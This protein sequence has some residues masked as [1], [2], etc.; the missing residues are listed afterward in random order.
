MGLRIPKRTAYKISCLLTLVVSACLSLISCSDSSISEPEASNQTHPAANSTITSFPTPSLTKVATATLTT[1]LKH[2]PIPETRAMGTVKKIDK[3]P[4]LGEVQETTGPIGLEDIQ[5][6]PEALDLED[7]Q[8]IAGTLD[9]EDIQEIAGTLD[10]EDIQEIAEALDLED[11]PE[12]TEDLDLEALLENL[13]SKDCATLTD[14]IQRIGCDI[15]QHIDLGEGQ[16]KGDTCDLEPDPIE[17]EMCRRAHSPPREDLMGMDDSIKSGL[18]FAPELPIDPANPP[19]VATHNFIDLEPFIRIT[20][21]RSAYGHNYNYGSPEYDPTGVSCSS[22]KHYF[23]A[24]NSDQRWSGNFGS[25]DTRGVVKF[26]SPVDG[27]LYQVITNEIEQGTEYQFYISPTNYQKLVFTF[28]HVDLLEEFVD[29]GSVTAGQHLGYIIRPNGQGEI[30]VAISGDKT[31]YISFFDVMTDEVFAEY[32]GRGIMNRAQMT[33]PKQ[34]RVANPIP[35]TLNDGKGGKFYS[36]SGNQE[37]FNVWQDGP[38]NWIEL[39]E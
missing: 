35:C 13:E 3:S 8:E 24:Y 37:D 22:M 1:K 39:T 25:Y 32:Q 11:I 36:P 26:Y 34:E 38:D 30:A 28:H 29:G 20:K 9:L 21:I 2:T 23:D 17:R 10:L 33:I 14:P 15:A 18:G 6:I 31:E 5:E 4:D 16:S 19:K 12:T 27:D 7:I